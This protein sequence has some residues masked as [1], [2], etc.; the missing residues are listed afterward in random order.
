MNKIYKCQDF[1]GDCALFLRRNVIHHTNS[2]IIVRPKRTRVFWRHESC[3]RRPER[4]RE[5]PRDLLRMFGKTQQFS[6]GVRIVCSW[7]QGDW[8][9]V[10]VFTGLHVHHLPQCVLS[11]HWFAHLEHGIEAWTTG[12]LV[13]WMFDNNLPLV[14]TWSCSTSSWA[15]FRH[16]CTVV[17]NFTRRYG[18]EKH[19]STKNV[20]YAR[21]EPW[22]HI[23]AS[24]VQIYLILVYQS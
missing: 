23:A 19:T 10:Y 1:H 2:A 4:F 6:V 21:L 20:N 5:L 24:F 18:R 3:R 11:A 7:R 8:Q 14:M 22:C 16:K 12:R 17:R 15:S 13:L 9:L